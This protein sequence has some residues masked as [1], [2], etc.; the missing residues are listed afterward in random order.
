[1]SDGVDEPDDFDYKEVK[2]LINEAENTKLTQ[3]PFSVMGILVKIFK[4]LH[5]LNERTRG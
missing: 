1:M 5:R 4:I 3:N 2:E